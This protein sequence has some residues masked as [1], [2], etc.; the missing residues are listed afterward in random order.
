MGGERWAGKVQGTPEL[1]WL[2]WMFELR[3]RWGRGWRREGGLQRGKFS[4]LLDIWSAL[5]IRLLLYYR[6]FVSRF[7]NFVCPSR[8]CWT[9]SF[10]FFFSDY[11][12]LEGGGGGKRVIQRCAANTCHFDTGRNQKGKANLCSNSVRLVVLIQILFK[13]SFASPNFVV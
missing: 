5:C 13:G 9:L 2:I 8:D 3:G 11:F 10:Q 12:F 6:R 1:L 7:V 4:V